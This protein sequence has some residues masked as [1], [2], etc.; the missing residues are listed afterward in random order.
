MPNYDYHCNYVEEFKFGTSSIRKNMATDGQCQNFQ[1]HWYKLRCCGDKLVIALYTDVGCGGMGASTEFTLRT[2]ETFI[3]EGSEFTAIG[4]HCSL[5][6]DDCKFAEFMSLE[7][8][9][10]CGARVPPQRTG[11]ANLS[12]AAL[13]GILGGSIAV[14]LLVVWA[15][16]LWFKRNRERA[17]EERDAAD[18][19][20]M[21]D[22]D[23]DADALLVLKEEDATDQGDGESNIKQG[24]Q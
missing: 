19:E 11:L 12:E 13:A 8:T 17:N 18:I 21:N 5:L 9:N 15:V 16:Y 4:V 24:I 14:V 7:P 2:G 22:A 10:N 3:A 1:G 6:V 20:A 23:E